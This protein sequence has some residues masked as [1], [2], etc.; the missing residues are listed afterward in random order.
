[1][2][3]QDVGQV[4]GLNGTGKILVSCHKKALSLMPMC[5]SDMADLEFE[6]TLEQERRYLR[7]EYCTWVL[8]V[9]L[10]I[11]TSGIHIT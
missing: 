3:C 11:V 10:E 6:A 5:S 4:G 8:S 9:W 2:R 7:C 1:M